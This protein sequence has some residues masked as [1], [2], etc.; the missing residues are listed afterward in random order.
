M[1]A[2]GM[3]YS[4]DFRLKVLAA[5]DRGESEAAVAKRFDIG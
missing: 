4:K 1:E 2:Y 3:A 5:V